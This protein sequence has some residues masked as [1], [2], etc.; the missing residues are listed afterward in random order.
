MKTVKLVFAFAW[1]K[2]NREKPKQHGL[3]LE[4]TEEAF[5]DENKIIFADWKHSVTEQR[6]TLF[7]KTKQG[8]LLNITYINRGSKIRIITARPINKR[9]VHLYEKAT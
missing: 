6:V 7:G 5:F 8:K 3:T 4:E 2:G 1:D 9:E